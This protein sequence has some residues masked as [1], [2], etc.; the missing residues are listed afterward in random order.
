MIDEFSVMF[1]NLSLSLCHE[2]FKP[3]EIDLQLS[4]TCYKNAR[5]VAT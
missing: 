5:N 2:T 1:M 3:A 4:V